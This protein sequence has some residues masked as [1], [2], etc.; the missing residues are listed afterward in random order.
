M[1]RLRPRRRSSVKNVPPGVCLIG[2]SG[3][4]GVHYA[5][6][7]RLHF[8][9]RI[10]LTAAAVINEAQQAEKCRRL[11]EIGCRIFTDHEVMLESAAGNASLCVIPTGI[12][13]HAPMAI[14]AM[15]AGC[16][17]LV[18]KPAAATTAEIWKMQE[19]ERRTGRFV[20][21]GFQTLYAPE[22]RS[23]KQIILDGGIGDLIA[24]RCKG[25]WPR[26]DSYYARNS[27]AGRLRVGEA[28]VLDS[29]LNNAF[30]HELA[31]ACFL[32]GPELESAAEIGE[33]QAELYRARDMESADTGGLRAVTSEGVRLLFLFS[34]SCERVLDPE[35]EIIG[36]R[37]TISWNAGGIRVSAHGKTQCLPNSSGG[38]RREAMLETVIGRL[39]EPSRFVCGLNIAGVQ[40][41]CVNAAHES[42][43]VHSISAD[44]VQS[45]PSESSRIPAVSGIE[46]WV[47]EGFK[48]FLL[49]SELGALWGRPGR[50]VAI[51]KEF[52]AWRN[53]I[54]S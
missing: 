9:G 22:T 26:A 27:W 44:H 30:A 50:R 5:D 53:Q 16:H 33:V 41:L 13:C 8:E 20:A 46:H 14:R 36:R 19:A 28:W 51:G 48:R 54:L 6:L 1:V 34:H 39:A 25:L 15:A 21:V 38:A 7:V 47:E 35:M 2:I 37:G 52:P 24:I 12:F 10:R 4:A 32:A 49:F 31:M 23:V 3:Y 45:I 11:R 29:P 42:S 43:A 17:V 40:T 18:E